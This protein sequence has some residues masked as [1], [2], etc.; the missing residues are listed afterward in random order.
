[1]EQLIG[2]KNVQ[3]RSFSYVCSLVVLYLLALCSVFSPIRG[4]ASFNA[5]W[6]SL[7]SAW[8]LFTLIDTPIFIL[9]PTRFRLLMFVYIIYTISVAYITGNGA[10]GNR[11]FELAQIPLFY[12]AYEKNK[13][14]KRSNDSFWLIALL[15]PFVFYT[16]VVTF[17]ALLR[18]PWISRSI[19]TKE[20]G[21]EVYLRLGVGSYEYIYFLVIVF[22][23]L[24]FVLYNS[25][26]PLKNK[27]NFA[28]IA[29]LVAFAIIITMANFSTAFILLITCVF[30]RIFAPRLKTKYWLLYI[31]GGIVSLYLLSNVFSLLLDSLTSLLGNSLNSSRISE[32]K[33]LFLKNQTGDSLDSRN[34]KWLL[35]VNAFLDNPFFGI[36]TKPLSYADGFFQGFGQHS[37]ILDTFALYGA[38]VGTL[39]IYMFIKPFIS[40]LKSTKGYIPGFTLLIMILF[41]T[42]VT[43]DNITPSIGFAA[44]FIFPT[45]YD[46]MQKR[47]L[48]SKTRL[49]ML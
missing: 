23:I 47:E 44:F 45:V 7:L 33:E 24:L 5:I 40:R 43:F 41:F 42:M 10:I 27:N 4:L 11:Y 37:Q 2:I 31:I 46:W 48:A 19:A 36:L 18:D 22:G 6:A 17:F 49:K 15:T 13:S 21:T 16:G 1:M 34:D 35:S 32:I 9:Y 14:I 25:N 3:K 20:I 30:M 12:M 8:F 26:A 38:G 29:V 28:V 39:Q